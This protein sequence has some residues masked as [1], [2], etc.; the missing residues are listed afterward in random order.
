MRDGDYGSRG[1]RSDK[2]ARQVLFALLSHLTF[3]DMQAS[4]LFSEVAVQLQRK[5]AEPGSVDR[6]CT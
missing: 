1:A 3:S 6:C 4:K 2:A 5:R